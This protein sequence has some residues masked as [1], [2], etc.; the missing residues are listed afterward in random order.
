MKKVLYPLIGHNC[1]N[2]D[3][4]EIQKSVDKEVLHILGLNEHFPRAVLYA[5]FTLGGI[6]CT[7]IHG[8]HVIDKILLFVHHMWEKGQIHEA[9]LASMSTTQ[10]KCGSSEPFFNLDA[11]IWHNLVTP[12]W[13]SHIWQECQPAGIE[14]R[15]HKDCFWVPKPVR[16]HDISIMEVAETMYSGTQ[17]SQINMCRIAL[18]VIF[19]SDIASVDGRRILLSYYKGKPHIE[20]GRRTRINWP[21]VGTLPNAWWDL[22]RNFLERWCG[23]SLLIREP[24]GRWYAEVEMLTKCCCLQYERRLIMQHK[25][26]FYEFLPHSSRSRTRYKRQAYSFDELHL[27]EMANVVDITFKGDNIYVVATSTQNVIEAA[28]KSN[29]RSLQDLYG[30]LPADLQRIIGTVDWPSP[31]ALLDVVDSIVSGQAIGLSDG[32]VRESLGKASHAWIIQAM[33][34]S[35]IKGRGPVDG[36]ADARTW[37][38]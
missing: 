26:G 7:S 16:E 36:S 5:P 1:R 30:D 24:L 4:S 23:T 29:V 22:W 13:I 20:S 14:L 19:L 18:Q 32:S 21:P 6:G 2:D 11:N 8:Q 10:I 35:E 12:M 3:L 33:N 27:L 34:G 15:F 37:F 38:H 28:I 25:G 31:H 17:L 9:M